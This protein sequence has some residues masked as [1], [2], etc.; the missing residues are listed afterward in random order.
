[1]KRIAF[2]LLAAVPFFSC[3]WFDSELP[4]SIGIKT[5][6]KYEFSLGT[7]SG[8]LSEYLSV[9]TLTE[10][11]GDSDSSIDFK[12]YDYYPA[13]LDH[14]APQMQQFLIDFPIKTVTLDINDHLKQMDFSTALEKMS[15]APDVIDLKDFKIKDIDP[16]SV[17]PGINQK[18]EESANLIKCDVT[19]PKKGGENGFSNEV[20]ESMTATIK[21]LSPTFDKM[22]FYEARIDFTATPENVD[23]ERG[24]STNLTLGLF[25]EGEKEPVSTIKNVNLP[26][27]AFSFPLNGKTI[28]P[29][30]YIKVISGT[31]KNSNGNDSASIKYNLE[32]TLKNVKVQTVTNLTIDDPISVPIS[33]DT[34]T[35]ITIDIGKSPKCEI[36]KGSIDIIAE[37]NETRKKWTGVK[38]EPKMKLEGAI[39]ADPEDFKKDER[40][41]KDYF[42]YRT[43]SLNGVTYYNGD[44]IIVKGS[45]NVNIKNAN[46]QFAENE[47]DT[48]IV[49]PTC[50][51][52]EISK[53]WLELA[54]DDSLDGYDEKED[55]GSEITKYITE[56][57]IE[58]PSDDYRLFELNVDYIN[59]LPEGNDIDLAVTSE[60][61]EI[62]DVKK[63]LNAGTTN[64]QETINSP[65]TLIKK[66]INEGD[67]ID[68]NINWKIPGRGDDPA[69]PKCTILKN[70]KIGETYEL[71][72]TVSPVFNW[73]Y[74]KI[75][76]NGITE[77]GAINTGLNFNSMFESLE[78]KLV[79]ADGKSIV[80]KIKLIRMPLYFYCIMP[81]KGGIELQGKIAVGTGKIEDGKPIWDTT[82]T[83]S[84]TKNPTP[85]VGKK[86]GEEIKNEYGKLETEKSLPKLQ[87]KENTENANSDDETKMIIK[88]VGKEKNDPAP[89][90]IADLFNLH[91]GSNIIFEYGMKLGGGAN[92]PIKL[93]KLTL[94]SD[95]SEPTKIQFHA[96][97]VIPLE[98]EATEDINLS[99]TK[100]LNKEDDEDLFNRDE[101][102]S[103]DTVEDL[104]N[105]L[106]YAQL[107][108]YFPKSPSVIQFMSSSGVEDTK[109]NIRVEIDTKVDDIT[110]KLDLGKNEP[111]EIYGDDFSKILKEYPFAPDIQFVIPQ[112]CFYIRHNFEYDLRMELGAKFNNEEI[113]IFGG[114][115]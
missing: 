112:G 97:I 106:E 91:G 1:M 84:P 59:T 77:E 61:F 85:V 11:L 38:I 82:S 13:Y 68:F 9:Q 93:S 62:D 58:S 80:N 60:Y 98:I 41:G 24:F 57:G 21:I 20:L 54:D 73:D 37:Q 114:K 19:I 51:I 104:I 55:L 18:I 63:T 107:N 79:G 39:K 6:A 36:G 69:Y 43:K 83:G 70:L 10:S 66:E 2:F 87:F 17:K 102:T 94:Q 105:T 95:D 53:L 32:S 45:V 40:E 90:D 52:E 29:N 27:G 12:I 65:R 25:N 7:F 81:F 31:A 15:F 35:N 42:I 33:N 34:G 101:A 88:E 89:V 28:K 50:N 49:K 67:K 76:A 4:K 103:N 64:K 86:E 78:D 110:Y 74:V 108:A 48:I 16:I 111:V 99:F 5:E 115:K 75:K 22:Q 109:R 92:E 44:K 3:N 46:I 96:R 23:D 100:L 72:V 26:D 56:F 47:D 8:N 14:T 30:L 113:L 71:K